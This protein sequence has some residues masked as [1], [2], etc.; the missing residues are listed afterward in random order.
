MKIK[1]FAIVT[2]DPDYIIFIVYIATFNISFD[3]GNKVH[4]SQRA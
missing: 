3:I 2:I 4:P 1:E